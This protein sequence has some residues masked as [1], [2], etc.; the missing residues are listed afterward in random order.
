MTEE[1]FRATLTSEQID[2]L[3]DLLTEAYQNG[4]VY[5][6]SN[7]YWEGYD[8]GYKYGIETC[9]ESDEE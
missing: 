7:E 5:R 3:D 4:D 6:R 1:Q 2:I 8:V 9:E